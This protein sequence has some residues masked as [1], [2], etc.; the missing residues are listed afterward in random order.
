MPG[1]S[2]EGADKEITL[3]A[4]RF[5]NHRQEGRSAIRVEGTEHVI[6]AGGGVVPFDLG[7]L[8]AHLAA[9]DVDAAADAVADGGAV[10]AAGFVVSDARID[11]A[12]AGV[13]EIDPPAETVAALESIS[14]CD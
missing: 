12:R 10:A 3:A 9:G 14:P 13:V 5:A 6:V 2:R 11:D 8:D 7:V 4:C 1:G